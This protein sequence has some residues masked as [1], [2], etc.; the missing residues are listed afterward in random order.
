MWDYLLDFWAVIQEQP[1]ASIAL[2]T[3]MAVIVQAG[4]AWLQNIQS[5]RSYLH[6]DFLKSVDGTT[7][8]VVLKNSGLGPAIILD[9][10]IVHSDKEYRD[11]QIFDLFKSTF[12]SWSAR[13]SRPNDA[14]SAGDITEVLSV[15][16]TEET[17]DAL[18]RALAEQFE[19]IVKYKSFIHF[20]M[21]SKKYSSRIHD[22]KS[23]IS[24]TLNRPH[25]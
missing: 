23:S 18:Q 15:P 11:Q 7:L 5:V 6:I 4:M 17:Q 19:L 9:Y 3:A 24:R 10:Y 1:T 20:S 25:K 16:V 8:H 12:P 22:W 14:L 13:V 21:F 2:I